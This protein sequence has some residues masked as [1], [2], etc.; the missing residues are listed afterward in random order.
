MKKCKICG[1]EIPNRIKI[2]GVTKNISNRANCLECVPFGSSK[3]RVKTPQEHRS[4][5]AK[6]A[7]N[8]YNRKKE[9]DGID[10]VRAIR[11]KK[12]Q[13][14]VDAL[15]GGCQICGYNKTV[16]NLAFHHLRDKEFSISSRAFQYSWDRILPELRKCILVC[17]NC[18]GE[19]HDNLIDDEIVQQR[20]EEAIEAIDKL[21]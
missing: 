11:E 4:R 6:N 19:I 21:I 20:Y 2:N 15:G 13:L 9:Q 17:H 1:K 16:K 12:K 10:P 8:Y 7:R 18:H 14:I 3:T 5:K